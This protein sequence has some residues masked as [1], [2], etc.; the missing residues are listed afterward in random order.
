MRSLLDSF[1][2]LRPLTT[3]RAALALAL[4]SASL[5]ACG[6]G[7][8]SDHEASRPASAAAVPVGPPQVLG[9]DAPGAVAGKFLV[10]L[11]SPG[12]AAAPRAEVGATL[13]A[14]ATDYDGEVLLVVDGR[15]PGGAL[16][17]DRAG[18]KAMASDPRVATIE[19][20]LEVR[21]D[22]IQE[23]APWGLDR[24]DQFE[25]PLNGLYGYPAAP[26][27][28][29]VY[30]VDTGF[31]MHPEFTGRLGNGVDTNPPNP[32]GPPGPQ[33][34]ADCRDHGTHVAGIVGGA[35][36]GVAKSAILHSV[37]VLNCEARGDS[38]YVLAG[39]QWIRDNFQAPAV[40][41]MSLSIPVSSP[42]ASL[43]EDLVEQ[44]IEAGITVVAS[45]GNDGVDACGFIP[46]RTVEVLTVGAYDRDDRL[47]PSSN[48]GNCVDLY[49]PGVAIP[50]AVVGGSAEK[51][52]TSMA[53]PHVAGA[54]ALYL[55]VYPTA[56]RAEVATDLLLSTSGWLLNTS[57]LYGTPPPSPRNLRSYVGT[58]RWET[59]FVW[60]WAPGATSYQVWE[61]PYADFRTASLVGTTW[62]RELTE[63]FAGPRYVAVSA[64]NHHGC[65]PR[66]STATTKYLNGCL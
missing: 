66:S 46:A 48:R 44:L 27:P 8:E 5:V 18:A 6:V 3:P 40:V 11:A 52:G 23:A 20:A 14:L 45:A 53:A 12:L 10:R 47:W 43:V 51:T 29:H 56:S 55:G 57:F 35:T 58:C 21:G 2:H 19:A 25:R 59:R 65:G 61:S 36:F 7:A 22:A 62:G 54:A 24:I 34:S 42:G 63:L 50:S 38:T 33:P 9:L 1:L 64:C 60:D 32:G 15:S 17:L 37:R 39:L 26:H 41:N 49:A 28:V 13:A 16:R 31:T 4:V 30:V